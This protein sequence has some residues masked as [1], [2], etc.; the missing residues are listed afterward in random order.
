VLAK[1]MQDMELRRPLYYFT[2]PGMVRVGIGTF[3]GLSFLRT[4]YHGGSLMFGPTLL[5][6]MLSVIGT[7][8]VFMGIILHSMSMMINETQN[9]CD[10]LI[11]SG[12]M[13]RR[14]KDSLQRTQRGSEGC[15][16]SLRSFAFICGSL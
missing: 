11:Y 4:F 3:M 5:M 14:K 9:K 13:D 12:K 7:F 15:Y 2:A 1:V 10:F 16:F 6:I 8:M